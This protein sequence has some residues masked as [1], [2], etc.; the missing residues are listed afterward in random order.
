M[1]ETPRADALLASLLSG[2]ESVEGFATLTDEHERKK[3][4]HVLL[5]MLTDPSD[6]LCLQAVRA[7]GVL[8]DRRAVEPLLNSLDD[9][10]EELFAAKV[11]ALAVLRD[12]EAIQPLVTHDMNRNY[13]IVNRRMHEFDRE[14]MLCALIDTAN[15]P[16]DLVRISVINALGGIDDPRSIDV[17]IK[18]LDDNSYRIRDE[19]IDRLVRLKA[20]E[21]VPSLLLHTSDGFAGMRWHVAQALGRL[22]DKRAIHA[23]LPLLNDEDKRVRFDAAFALGKLGNPAGAD[24]ICTY[25]AGDHSFH[26]NAVDEALKAF[27]VLRLPAVPLLVDLADKVLAQMSGGHSTLKLI[28]EMFAEQGDPALPVLQRM[29][30]I[31]RD[32]AGL[33]ILR[34][35]ADTENKS[36]Q[37]VAQQAIDHIKS[38]W[39]GSSD[40]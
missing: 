8:G 5:A 40:E 28:V 2:E 24:L 6:A 18:A 17:L 1:T 23:L 19:S 31:E 12:P 29:L 9:R 39:A 25:L 36:V 11:S 38:N 35:I 14:E 32:D 26:H 4:L 20:I 7:L 30:G 15:H 13:W 34:T 37:H 21:A 33:E 10:D 3:A 22:G 16:D 27:Q